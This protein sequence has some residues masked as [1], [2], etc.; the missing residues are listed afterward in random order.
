MTT[1]SYESPA[2]DLWTLITPD[3]SRDLPIFLAD[4]DLSGWSGKVSRSDSQSVTRLG[5]RSTGWKLDP[6]KIEIPYVAQA[7][8][9]TVDTVLREWRRAW[10]F[11]QPGDYG[12][13]TTVRSGKLWVA[14]GGESY[15]APVCDPEFPDLPKH[16]QRVRAVEEVMS[17]RSMV[18]HWFGATEHFEG[19]VSIRVR[20]DRPLSPSLRLAWDG[21]ATSVTFPSGLKLNLPNVGGRRFINLDRGMSGQVTREDGSVD[22]GGWSALQGL[23]HGLSLRP[24]DTSDWVL[25]PG[26]TLE[27]TPRFL[28]PW[29]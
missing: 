13:P 16:S 11:E 12:Y 28:T 20:G 1:V 5:A 7:L 15:W 29:R 25:G 18:G 9:G 8:S 23:V 26:L 4:N 3:G 6:L 19:T 14:D 10:D 22:T 27:V 17:C 24:G 21:S 2:G